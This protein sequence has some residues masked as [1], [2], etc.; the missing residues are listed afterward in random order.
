M[1]RVVGEAKTVRMAY[2]SELDIL[3]EKY[4]KK[5]WTWTQEVTIEIKGGTDSIGALERLGAI[6]KSFDQTP[7]RAENIAILGVVTEAMRTE[8]NER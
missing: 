5:T 4:N 1:V 7:A 3:F 8:L 6:K 2:G